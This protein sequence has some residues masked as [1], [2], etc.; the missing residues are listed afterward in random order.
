MESCIHRY[1]EEFTVYSSLLSVS[2][3]IWR[4]LWINPS[5][6]KTSKFS[7]NRSTEPQSLQN[8]FNC[9]PNLLHWNELSLRVTQLLFAPK[10]L[11]ENRK[12]VP[13]SFFICETHFS[14]QE[15]ARFTSSLNPFPIPSPSAC[16]LRKNIWSKVE[17]KKMCSGWKGLKFTV[18]DNV[19]EK[20]MRTSWIH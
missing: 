14:S 16:R 1:E 15:R 12:N 7:K 17:I 19:D 18:R 20:N 11:N 8:K 4:N 13:N 10:I 2:K 6:K 3:L 5:T 9:F